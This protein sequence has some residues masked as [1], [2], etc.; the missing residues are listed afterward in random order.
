MTSGHEARDIARELAGKIEQLCAQLLPGAVR[1]GRMLRAGSLAGEPGQSLGV[2]LAGPRRG[3]WFEFNGQFGGDALDLVARSQCGGDLGKALQWARRW[4]GHDELGPEAL[5]AQR[6]RAEKAAA[7]RASEAERERQ[8][9]ARDAKALWLKAAPLRR[10]DIVWRYLAGR[11]IDLG[12]LPRPPGALR[13]H[14]A[15]YHHKSGRT[16]PAMVAAISG[17][18]GHLATQRT[19]LEEHSN[20]H[21]TKAPLGHD[22]KMTLGAFRAAGGAIHLTR[23]QSAKPWGRAP[24]GEWLA[25]AEGI[26]D[27]LTLACWVPELRTAACATSLAYLTHMV[28]PPACGGIYVIAQNDRLGSDAMRALRRGITGLRERGLAVVVRRPPAFLKDF[29]DWARWLEQPPQGL[30]AGVGDGCV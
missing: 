26:E 20:G 22:V 28:V 13:C 15:L 17:P 7:R 5:Q 21:V 27:A 12:C 29:N 1:D 25:V 8:R 11:A 2:T 16:F 14:P 6:E 9:K 30:L 19:W 18:G 23:G 4:L 10:G 24:A 3:R